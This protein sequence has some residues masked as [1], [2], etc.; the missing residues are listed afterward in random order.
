MPTSADTG[1]V[2][3]S[4]LGQVVVGKRVAATQLE[5]I[6]RFVHNVGQNC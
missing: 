2:I 6:R 5:E 4:Q 3:G 1:V